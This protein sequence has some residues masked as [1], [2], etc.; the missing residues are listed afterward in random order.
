[1]TDWRLEAFDIWKNMTEPDWANVNY[2]KPDFQGIS[3]Y[4]APKPKKELESLDEV[5]PELLKTFSKLGISL[6]EQKRLSGV[7]MDCNRLCFCG[8]HI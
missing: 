3:Y 5:D 6:N 7:A 8:Y 2:E 4:S 1:M